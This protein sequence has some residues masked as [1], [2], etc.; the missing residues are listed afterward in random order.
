MIAILIFGAAVGIILGL[1]RFKVFALLPVILLF[2][3]G[4][5][6]RGIAT[7]LEART[8]AFGLL[9]AVASPQIAY[10]VSAIGT[11]FIVAEYLRLRARNQ[12][13]AL[14][15][16]IRTTIGRELRAAFEL[17]QDLPQEMVALLARMNEQ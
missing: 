16:A 14:Y 2:A 10:V 3:A 12:K 6:A 13:P 4:T 15:R 8:I 11:D 17:P 5:I 9:A 7:G 1:G